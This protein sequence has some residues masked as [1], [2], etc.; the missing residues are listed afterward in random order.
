MLLYVFTHTVGRRTVPHKTPTCR[1]VNVS[2]TSSEQK[3]LQN[4]DKTI[5]TNQQKPIQKHLSKTFLSWQRAQLTPK[6]HPNHQKKITG[7]ETL[8]KFVKELATFERCISAT[9]FT[10]GPTTC[11]CLHQWIGKDEHLAPRV[12]S[13]LLKHQQQDLQKEMEVLYNWIRYAMM[14]CNMLG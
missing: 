14:L 5:A 11:N 8:T 4:Y 6:I 2:L 13:A 1:F 10:S 3:S 9:S 12:A 7:E